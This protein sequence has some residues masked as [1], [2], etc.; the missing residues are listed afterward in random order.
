M[1]V[2]WNNKHFLF[3]AWSLVEILV[4]SYA[5]FYNR[6]FRGKKFIF[7][8]FSIKSFRSAIHSF[9]VFL[10][11]KNETDWMKMTLLS[12]W[13]IRNN[14]L[15]RWSNETKWNNLIKTNSFVLLTNTWKMRIH[16]W[17]IDDDNTFVRASVNKTTSL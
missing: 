3:S 9:S 10:M 1:F 8:E 16:L 2:V 13:Q 11:P 17:R 14:R 4:R 7:F 12:I 5:R 6:F 15:K